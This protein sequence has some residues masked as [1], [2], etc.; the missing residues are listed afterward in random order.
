MRIC[1]G[2]L[3]GKARGIA[4]SNSL[5]SEGILDT[6]FP[7]VLIR[8]PKAY[9]IATSEYDQFM[10]ENDLWDKAVNAKTNKNIDTLF[11]KSKLTESIEK[12]LFAIIEIIKNPI[13]VRS[14]SLLED[15]Q[16]QPLSGAYATYMLPNS[17]TKTN[18]RFKQLCAA[19]K[20]V[21][22][23]MFHKEAIALIESS[24]HLL[25]EE[26]M[27]VIIMELIGQ[28]KD[29]RFYPTFSGTAQS[30]NYYP[31]SYMDR[32]EG[33]AYVALGL[34]RTVAEGEK[35]LRF[36][37]KYPAILPQYYSVKATLNSSQNSFY[38]LDLNKNTKTLLNGETE[39]LDLFDLQIA[40]NDKALKWVGSVVSNEDNVLRDSLKHSGTRVI[41]FAPILK[42]GLFPL[43]NILNRLL[44]LGKRSLGCEV[45]IEFAVNLFKD[46]NQQ[47][48]FCILQIKPMVMGVAEELSHELEM[49]SENVICQSSLTLGNG[50]FN[51]INDIIFVD[52]AK[53]KSSQTKIIA[54]EIETLTAQLDSKT[55][56]ILI[57]PGRWGTA[58]P[59]LGIPVKWQQIN[60]AKII[61]E[62]GLP[63]FPVD[64]SFGSHFFQ[65]VTSMRLGY[66]TVNHKSKQDKLDLVWLKDQTIIQELKFTQWIKTDG[67]LNA[68]INGHSGEGHILKPQPEI[69]QAM[70]EHEATGI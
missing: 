3:G 53:F 40:E 2:S 9:V 18:V 51:D 47:P 27:A 4:F 34:G 32:N 36:S 17:D 37:P 63:E 31:V 24:V 58:D 42:F 21:Y 12:A 66:F 35:S 22:A 38:A 61:V 55:P 57:G 49:T 52:P 25:E 56:Y 50:Q 14:S 13:A 62:V 41:T 26:K 29:N 68:I 7:G 8:V 45:E 67:P 1:P 48:E 15:S 20:L 54:K 39:N 11:Q 59:W 65:N 64:P 10:R 23:S 69:P 43:A 16:Y 28:K 19:V 30:F 60:G 70:D 33:V 6:D 44:E 46:K 5:I